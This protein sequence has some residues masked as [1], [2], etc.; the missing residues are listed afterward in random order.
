MSEPDCVDGIILIMEGLIALISLCERGY[1]AYKAYKARKAES[2]R[3]KA[4]MVCNGDSLGE[5]DPRIDE[6]FNLYEMPPPPHYP[7]GE[8]DH[9]SEMSLA[10]EVEEAPLR[11][12]LEQ[13]SDDKQAVLDEEQLD[14]MEHELAWE[15][16]LAR[17][18]RLPGA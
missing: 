7:N 10:E 3:M 1:K 2:K 8:E 16:E 13:S 4:R 12:D 15:L 18:E 6:G 17:M 5:G 9:T 11:K 14:S